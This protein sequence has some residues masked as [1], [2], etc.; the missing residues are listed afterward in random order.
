MYP[1]MGFPGGD[2]G[3]NLPANAGDITGTGWIPGLGRSPRGG[4]SNPLQCSCLENPRDGEAWWAAVS[5]AA[6]S[7]TQ[8]KRLSRAISGD[9]YLFDSYLSGYSYLICLI[10]L[11]SCNFKQDKIS[12][13]LKVWATGNILM[14]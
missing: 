2:S 11:N 10:F 1:P 5:G 13:K 4:H 8:L 6:Q 9:S 14:V 12:M 7:Q 3:K